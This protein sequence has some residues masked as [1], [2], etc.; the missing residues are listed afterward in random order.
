MNEEI[1]D[2]LAPGGSQTASGA[3]STSR[4]RL[5]SRQCDDCLLHE[6]VLILETDDHDVACKEEFGDCVSADDWE[7][8]IASVLGEEEGKGLIS[9]LE[10]RCTFRK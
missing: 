1:K 8:N 6:T 9:C 3:G 7:G 10:I 5:P 2:R 4:V